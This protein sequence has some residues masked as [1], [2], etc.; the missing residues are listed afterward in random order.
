LTLDEELELPAG[1]SRDVLI[2][3]VHEAPAA[4]AAVSRVSISNGLATPI[5]FELHV[6][7]P[8][9]QRIVH[10]DHRFEYQ[11]GEPL[12]RLTIPG[13]ATAVVHYETQ[14]R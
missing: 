8:W 13:K 6:Q 10:A 14:P 4:R 7:L 2:T 12:F 5:P 11:R 9:N 3:A 1:T